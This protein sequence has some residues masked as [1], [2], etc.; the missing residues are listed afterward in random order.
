MAQ[1]Q[2]YLVVERLREAD[3]ETL[4]FVFHVPLPADLIVPGD[5][6]RIVGISNKFESEDV[7]RLTPSEPVH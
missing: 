7:V 6:V 5:R 2:R 3:G 4:Q 1:E